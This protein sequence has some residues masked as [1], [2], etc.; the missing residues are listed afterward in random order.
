MKIVL[1]LTSLVAA[2]KLTPA[3]A[4][5]LKTLAAA[6]TGAMA[7]NILLAFGTVAVALGVGVLLPTPQ[8][9][10]L[11]G[12]LMLAMGLLLKQR[13]QVRWRVFAQI[14]TVTGALGVMAALWLLA[15]GSV[16][17]SLLLALGLAGSAVVAG[18]GLLAALSVLMLAAALGSSTAYWTAS[19]F[20][21]VERPGL[22][23][24]VLGALAMGLVW[25]SRRVGAERERLAIIAART[26][27]L[28]VN[29]AFLVG[30]IFGDALLGWP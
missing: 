26:A 10:L 18:S 2:G 28:V 27:V 7:T 8:T 30:S 22:T 16:W 11:I 1:D 5:R 20:L 17:V 29:L 21:G 4:E 24:L 19:Y 3:E 25:L 9:A 23:I 15:G 14:I 13:G 12:G 6:D